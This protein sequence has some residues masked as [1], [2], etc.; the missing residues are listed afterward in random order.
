MSKYFPPC[1]NSENIKVELDLSNYATKKDIKDITHVDTSSYA[2]K[3]NLAALKTEV[4]KIDTDK[5]K[6]VPD[7]LA[8]LSNVVK[9]DVVK[10]TIYNTL[11]N[12]VDAIDTSGFVTRTKFTTDANALDDKID[13]VEKKIPD[14]SGLATKL[15][16]TRL[17]IEQEAYT[18]KVKK[19]IPDISGLASKT[20]LTAVENKIP[21][22]SGLPAASPLT[23]VETKIPDITSLITKTDFDAKLKNISDI[24]TNNK[25]KDLLLDNELK[26]LKTLVGSS[27][28]IKFDEL[29]KEN[30]FN[31]GFFCYLQQSCLVYDS[32]IGSFQFTAG[33]ISTW[34]ST[35]TLNYLGN[36]N[37]NAVG[38]SK[39]VLPE[40]K[41]DGRMHVSL[42]G[43]H[44]QQNKVIIPNNNNVINIYC[45]YELQPISSSRYDTFTIQNPLF[46]AMKITKNADT[47]KYDYKGYGICFDEG[48]QFGH[49]IREG[50]F[51]HT[52]N[53]RN[54]LIFGADMSFSIHTTNRAN[55][56]Y[57]MGDG[58][59]QGIQDTTIYAEKNFCRNFT[60]LGKKFVLNLHYNGD[61]SYLFVNGRQE[62]NFK[63]KA[64]QLVKEKLCIG[65]LSDQWTASESEKTGLYGNSYDFVVDYEQ[66][67]EVGPIYD[68]HRYLMIKHNTK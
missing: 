65:N 34:K 33:K 41:N 16:V 48:T 45:V 14:I 32:K 26:Q 50:G 42:S 51:D 29:Q 23:A 20:E 64:D 4:D 6:T 63:C 36:S 3:T 8:K 18:D 24:V 21:D 27:A 7:D 57:V 52:T 54:V 28:K 56:I 10:K 53:A 55:H 2:L 9:N 5:L 11:K 68:F 67:M 31:R 62:L 40:L 30:S 46:G 13:K 22:V 37:K 19:E 49:I 25:S 12:K 35:G 15:S 59:A 43:N 39:S 66:I 1:N 17:I 60:N 61:E 58:F 44:F 38:N 47:S